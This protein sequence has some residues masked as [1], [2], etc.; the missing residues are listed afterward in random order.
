MKKFIAAILVLVC[1]FQL[2]ACGE[3]KATGES[4]D[5]SST[6]KVRIISGG[7]TGDLVIAGQALGD[8]MTINLGETPIVID[9][10]EGKAADLKDGMVLEIKGGSILES[11]PATLFEVE[12][13]QAKTDDKGNH[14]IAGLYIKTLEDLWK[15]AADK[16]T[17][18][19]QINVDLSQAPGE[20][21]SGEKAAIA[22]VFAGKHGVM[23]T[24]LTLDELKEQGYLEKDGNFEKG[25][26]LSIKQAETPVGEGQ[27]SFDTAI[28][29]SGGRTVIFAGCTAALPA[30]GSSADLT[31]EIGETI[32]SVSR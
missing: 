22:W 18:W 7:G 14:N 4:K 29:P 20:L 17:K 30:V 31:Y 24:T 12:K 10:K 11:F 25:V 26:L 9:G 2:A 8:I 5:G 28:S 6:M 16:D 13:I 23:P 15:E 1:M 19:E 21:T 32:T 27:L 3:Q